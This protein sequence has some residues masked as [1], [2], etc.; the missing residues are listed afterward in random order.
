M[1]GILLLLASLLLLEFMMLLLFAAAD[2]DV[3]YLPAAANLPAVA[4]PLAC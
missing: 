4:D 1:V 3:A 2:V